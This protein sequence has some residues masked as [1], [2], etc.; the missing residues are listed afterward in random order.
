MTSRNIVEYPIRALLLI[1]HYV[2]ALNIQ[3]SQ[4]LIVTTLYNSVSSSATVNHTH[5]NFIMHNNR[6]VPIQ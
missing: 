4:L 5:W 1:L 3:Y 2:I 6:E